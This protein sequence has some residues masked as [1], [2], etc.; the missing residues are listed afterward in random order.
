[1][2]KLAIR[3]LVLSMTVT[4][5]VAAPIVLPVEAATKVSKVKKTK[6]TAYRA[7]PAKDPGA[8][9]FSH[10]IYDDFDRKNGGGGGGY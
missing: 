10:D 1:M 3:L 2:S 4:G 6:R 9:P 7:P 5:L 8:S